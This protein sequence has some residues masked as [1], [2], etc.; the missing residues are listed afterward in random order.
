[1]IAKFKSMT[2]ASHLKI[3]VFLRLILIIYGELQD[4]ISEVPYTDVD[5][6][7]VTDGAVH[8]LNGRSPFA[9]NTYRYTPLLAYIV[10][11]NLIIHSAF[12]KIIFSLIDVLVGILIKK[13]VLNEN[14]ETFVTNFNAVSRGKHQKPIK[15]PQKYEKWADWSA[16]IWLYNPLTM[17]IATRGNGDSLSSLLVLLSIYFLLHP[18]K[19]ASQF[20]IAGIFHGLAIHIRLYPIV[21]SLPYYLTLTKSGNLIAQF[22]L[23][24]RNKMLLVLS[25]VLTLAGITYLFYFLYGYQFLY[26]SIIYHLVRKDTRHNFSL[27]FYMQYLTADQTPSIVEKVLTFLPQLIVLIVLII[28][29]GHHRKTIPFCLFAQAF[30]MVT[31]NPVVTSQYFVWFLSLL[32][33]CV[34]NFKKIGVKTGVAYALIWFLGQCGWLL[35]AY[36][37]E[38]KG[39]NTFDFIWLQGI[40]FFS[41]N[42]YILQRL[43]T[44]FDVVSDF[45]KVI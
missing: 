17:V 20:I 12:G 31:Y 44:N 7:V 41:A 29:F 10:I 25:T 15:L 24:N 38:F 11:P 42:I 34:K 21:F 6:K 26:E 37:L 3:S 8:V 2:F 5:Y 33:L 32:P 16:L 22:L 19:K 18:Q 1:M 43:V 13:L 28:K 27:Y 30:T 39:W 23:P 9:R 45:K 40:L 4:A 36:F 35:P 14:E